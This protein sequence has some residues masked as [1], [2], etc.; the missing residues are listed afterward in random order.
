MVLWD[1]DVYREGFKKTFSMNFFKTLFL[2][3]FLIFGF[4]SVSLIID[5]EDENDV[6]R[7]L[8]DQPKDHL[9][10]VMKA[11]CLLLRGK[12]DEAFKYLIKGKDQKGVYPAYMMARYITTDGTF[13]DI[14]DTVR[15]SEIIDSAIAS[16]KEVIDLIKSIPN[17]PNAT[18][19]DGSTV[20]YAL[21]EKDHLFEL[22]SFYLIS[23]GYFDRYFL[24]VVDH[25]AQLERSSPGYKE[26]MGTG[27]PLLPVIRH[28][29][30]A[31]YSLNILEEVSTHCS[32][33]S[34]PYWNKGLYDIYIEMCNNMKN[35][36]A[37]VRD[38]DNERAHKAKICKDFIK[39]EGK[40]CESYWNALVEIKKKRDA[41]MKRTAELFSDS[42]W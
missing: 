10:L 31:I 35:F 15:Y 6:D 33:N 41:V 30:G 26:G 13:R 34:N 42:S 14:E 22:A 8:Q 29:Q 5:C 38:L 19:T 12:K 9:L 16:Y 37:E 39:L 4:S 3:F 11:K 28:Y 1:K 21:L 27:V 20:L 18:S 2:L 32:Q 24:Q 23:S 36:V 40:F 17:Y 25:H 7:Q